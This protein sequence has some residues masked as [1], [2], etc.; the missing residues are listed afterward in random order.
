ME[1]GH[2]SAGEA[3][4]FVVMVL[5]FAGNWYLNAYR[6]SQVEKELERIRTVLEALS[7]Y[8]ARMEALADRLRQIEMKVFNFHG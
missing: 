7:D 3:L 1:W 6:L 5:G 2:I 4:T 8:K